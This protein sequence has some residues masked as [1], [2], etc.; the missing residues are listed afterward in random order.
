M[1]TACR[2]KISGA[3]DY[4]ALGKVDLVIEAVFEDPDLKKE[5]FAKLDHVGKPGAILA[6]N[7]SYQDIDEIAAATGRPDDVIGLHFFSP[8][9]IMKLLEV[10]RGAKTADDVLA[11]CMVLAKKIRKIPVMSGVCYGFIG[12]RMLQPYMREAQLCLIEGATP[13]P[14]RRGS[15]EVGHGNGP[16]QCCRSCGAGYW[17]QG[18]PGA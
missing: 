9:H 12:N 3:T 15:T 1:R 7:T 10:V 13:E 8:A 17:L 14:S 4:V 2:E 16:G 5:I 6:T 18:A 11:T